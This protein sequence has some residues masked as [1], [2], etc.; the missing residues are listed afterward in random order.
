MDGSGRDRDYEIEVTELREVRLLLSVRAADDDE[1]RAKALAGETESETDLRVEDIRSRYVIARGGTR[2][3][4]DDPAPGFSRLTPNEALSLLRRGADGSIHMFAGQAGCDALPDAV[5]RT[6]RAAR[7]IT[8]APRQ[9]FDGF[10]DHWVRAHMA[11]GT[12]IA[13]ASDHPED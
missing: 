3:H 10:M 8:L 9:S 1:A 13:F 6:L 4:D 11:D 2:D 5:T 12:I 7:A